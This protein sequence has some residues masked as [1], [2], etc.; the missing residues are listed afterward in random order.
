MT[1]GDASIPGTTFGS[2][3]IGADSSPR[4]GDVF[5][6]FIAD[7]TDIRVLPTKNDNVYQEP[8][9]ITFKVYRSNPDGSLG[10]LIYTTYK[11]LG[12]QYIIDNEQ[13]PVIGD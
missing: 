3:P 10:P 11:T 9:V 4:P 6:S 1:I 2:T 8:G 12:G 5:Y 13:T 7:Q